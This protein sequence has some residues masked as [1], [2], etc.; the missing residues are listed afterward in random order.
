MQAQSVELLTRDEAADVLRVHVA[1]LDRLVREG[2]LR[3]SK[4]GATVR[5][6]R[7]SIG[8][9]LAATETAAPVVPRTRRASRAAMVER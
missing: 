8:E 7:A 2:K 3:A 9:F 6:S 5:I 1:T 4:F